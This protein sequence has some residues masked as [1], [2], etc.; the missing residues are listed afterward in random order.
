MPI[1]DMAI[2][3]GTNTLLQHGKVLRTRC[4]ISQTPEELEG[5]T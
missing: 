2:S 1:E 5:N 3:K 4:I